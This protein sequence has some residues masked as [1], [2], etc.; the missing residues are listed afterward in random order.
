MSITDLIPPEPPLN[1]VTLAIGPG[2]GSDPTVPLTAFSAGSVKLTLNDG[3]QVT[4]SMPGNTAEAGE[5]SGYETDVWVYK[6]GDLWVRGRMLAIPQT[7]DEDGKDALS[8]TAVGYKRLMAYRFLHDD[9][10]FTNTDQGAIVWAFIDHTQSELN[11]DLGITQ[12][13]TTTGTLRDRTDLYK[14]GDNI[15]KRLDEL[16]A[17]INGVWWD[18]GPDLVLTAKDQD[19]FTHHTTPIVHGMNAR[20]IARKPGPQFGNVGGASGSK[21]QTTVEWREA[22]SLATDPR[23]RWEVFDSSH[24]SVTEQATV[25]EYAEGIL[26]DREHPP[27]VWTIELEPVQ[28]FGGDSDYE[29]GDFCQVVVPRSLADPLADPRVDVE[30]QLTE[31]SVAFDDSGGVTVN[32]TGVEVEGL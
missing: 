9:L 23:G 5:V 8:I 30:V 32:A 25:A 26:A 4:F 20:K 15:G 19:D 2:S 18:I 21:E 11:G 12:G 27:A 29:P 17:V 28:Y 14:I 3:P 10:G 1:R 7:W 16:A 6:L 24:G 22:A 31:I 13:S